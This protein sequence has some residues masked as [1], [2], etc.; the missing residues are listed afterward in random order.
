MKYTK[1]RLVASESREEISDTRTPGEPYSGYCESEIHLN[2][3][4]L[5]HEGM[6]EAKDGH[7]SLAPDFVDV[8]FEVDI[9]DYLYLVVVRYS[10]GDTFGQTSGHWTLA[11]AFKKKKEA[12]DLRTAILD[13]EW[14]P[15][16]PKRNATYCI[17][18]DRFFGGL[19]TV[20]IEEVMVGRGEKED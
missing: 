5:R 14:P 2:I 7:F 3:R 20:E 11:G 18:W 8:P 15:A 19:E 4:G 13:K 9:G 1:L 10:D 17:P 12:Q 16:S 6:H